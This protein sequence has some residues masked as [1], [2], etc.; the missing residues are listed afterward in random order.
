[1]VGAD[2]DQSG[3]GSAYVFQ[4]DSSGGGWSQEAKIA[5]EDADLGEFGWSVDVKRN[6]V[7]VGDT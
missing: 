6:T 3:I 2:N 7:V 5:P 1:M 4:S